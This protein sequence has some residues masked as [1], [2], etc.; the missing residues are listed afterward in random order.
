[1]HSTHVTDL[2][3]KIDLLSAI[4]NIFEINPQVRSVFQEVGGFVYV[5][6]ILVGLEGSLKT[7]VS[8]FWKKGNL[9]F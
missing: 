8:S 7:P 4:L 9:S 2:K 6:S 3:L 5:A 1:M